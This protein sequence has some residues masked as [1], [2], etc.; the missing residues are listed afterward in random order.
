MAADDI[1]RYLRGGILMIARLV[2][3]SWLL[4]LFA[5]GQQSA[6]A[7]KDQVRRYAEAKDWTAAMGIVDSEVART[8]ADMDVRAWRARVLTWSGR[9]ADA[10]IEYQNILTAAPNDPDIWLGLAAVFSR[11]GRTNE[12]L[13][14]LD[15][16]VELDPKRADIRVARASA[17]RAIGLQ[18]EAKLEFSR[19]LTLDPTNTEG[20]AGLASLRG[21]LRQELRVGVNTDLFNFT[22]ANQDEGLSLISNWTPHWTTAVS[23][24]GYHWGSTDAEKAVASVTRKAARWGALTVGGAAA[25]D[26]G[27]IPKD[28]GFFD[29]DQGFRLH[30]TT[31]LHG[32]EV[33]YGQHWY[34]YSS[35]RILTIHETTLFYLPRDWTWSLGLTGA[36]SHFSGTGSEWRPSGMT[37]LG[38]PIAGVEGHHLSGNVFFAVG[39]ENFAQLDQIGEFSSQTYG[40]GLRFQ[41]TSRQDVTGFGAYQMRSQGRTQSSFGFTYGLRF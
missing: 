16:A 26:N 27:V 19:A 41:L 33:V 28:E 10:E 17:L 36:R 30:R 6:L 25:H 24:D 38:F 7:W 29:Y 15:R 37:R 21:T 20:R 18:D 3:G 11:E 23:A 5:W 2:I 8:P 12:A 39:T 34:W 1:Y 31:F 13:Q 35:A 9:Y 4:C 32:L 40:G 14:T 22:A